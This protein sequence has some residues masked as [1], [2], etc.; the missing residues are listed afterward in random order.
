MAD[1]NSCTLTG[2][3]TRDAELVTLPEGKQILKCS[4]AVNT[5]YGQYAKTTYVKVQQWLNAGST[6]GIKQYLVKG[7]LIGCSGEISLSSWTTQAGETRSELVLTTFGI[8]ILKF[9]TEDTSAP[10]ATSTT[11]ATQKPIEEVAF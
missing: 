10:A 11:E 2:R 3:L 9:M 7:A 5:G 8:Q 6:C 1:L 4:I